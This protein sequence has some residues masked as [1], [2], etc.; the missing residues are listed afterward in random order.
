MATVYQIMGYFTETELTRRKAGIVMCQK[1]VNCNKNQGMHQVRS[2]KIRQKNIGCSRKKGR[3]AGGGAKGNLPRRGKGNNGRIK[4][5]SSMDLDGKQIGGNTGDPQGVITFGGGVGSSGQTQGPGA[6]EGPGN[7]YGRR[8]Y[9]Q[10]TKRS[11]LQGIGR[12]GKHFL[13]GMAT[14]EHAGHSSVAQRRTQ[15]DVVEAILGAVW[16]ITHAEGATWAGQVMHI[17]TQMEES[18]KALWTSCL[19]YTSDAADE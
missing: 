7:H 6:H 19:L 10:R 1:G 5:E 4:C 16:I 18:M 13:C 8:K 2:D 3:A 12:H 15:G 17:Q 9:D 11:N 14:T